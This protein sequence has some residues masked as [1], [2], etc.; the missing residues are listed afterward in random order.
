MNL[1][2]VLSQLGPEFKKRA[3]VF[4]RENKFVEENL[5]ALKE[6]GVYKALIPKDCGGHGISYSELCHFLNSLAQRCPATSLALSMHQHLIATLT[7]KHLKGDAASSKT[8]QMIAAKDLVLVSTGAADWLTSNGSAQKVDGGYKINCIKHFCSGS[9]IAHV[10]VMSCAYNEGEDEQVIHFS[11]PLASEG[12]EVLNDWN[13]MGMRG[14]GSHS[15]VFKDVFIPGEGI[16]LI[17][18]SG[19][20]HPLFNVV[21]VLAFTIIM[22]VY[23]GIAQ[24][25]TE[26]ALKNISD[27]PT[28]DASSIALLGRMQ[29]HFQIMKWA[30]DDMSRTANNFDFSPS[31]ENTNKIFQAKSL[32]AKNGRECAQSAMEALGGSSYLKSLELERLYR[33]I[34]AGEFH[35]IQ[36]GKQEAFLGSFLLSGKI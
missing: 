14:T 2:H 28:R 26:Y 30:F 31:D 23:V 29:N 22:S 4:D 20:W 12:V 25:I 8:L 9:P 17:R 34:M 16:N 7:F 1:E 13:A 6:M 15:I 21:S 5:L 35:P 3:P 10:A 32:I 19:A 36:S 27:R 33:D 18:K 11:A 24:A